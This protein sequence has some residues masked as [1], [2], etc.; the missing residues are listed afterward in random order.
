MD[1]PLDYGQQQAGAVPVV[2][3]GAGRSRSERR[4]PP[5]PSGAA[6]TGPSLRLIALTVMGDHLLDGRTA[7]GSQPAWDPRCIGSTK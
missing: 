2:S 5:A 1:V 7:P 3:G 6:A 4:T